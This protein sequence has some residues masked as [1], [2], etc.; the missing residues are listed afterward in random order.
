[1]P[2][3]DSAVAPVEPTPPAC[4]TMSTAEASVA[5]L[6]ANG[7]DTIY[8]LP[9]LHN[10]PF[11]DACFRAEG[12]LRLIHPRH[13]QTC[14]YMGLGA[15]L[16]TGKPQV[17][18]VVPGPGFLNT[19]AAVL[20]AEALCAPLLTIA[21]QIPQGDIDR[22]HGHLHEIRDQ[23]GLA[24]HIS[25]LSTRIRAPY[26]APA[27]IE[28]SL[29]AML[30]DRPGPAFIECAMDVWAQRAPVETARTTGRAAPL[31]APV[32]GEAVEKA[33]RIIAAAVNPMI[34]VGGG[35]LEAGEAVRA[36]AEHLEAPVLSYRRGRGVIP[37]DHRLAVSLPVGYRLWPHVDT[38]IAIGTRLFI[39]DKQWGLDRDIKV[40]RIDADPEA[41]GRGTHP[42]VS[43]IGDAAACTTALL[44]ATRS[45]RGAV[46][47]PVPDLEPHNAWLADRLSRLEPQVSYLAA[48]RRA[49]PRDGIFV[50]EVTQV[51]FASRLAFPV[52]EPR[53]FLSPG[54]QDNLGW[55]YGTA[56]GAQAANPDRAVVAVAGDGGFMYQVGEL[57]TAVLHKLPVVVIVF[58]NGMFGNV[59]RIQQERFGN[60]LIASDLANP[61][62]FKLADAFGVRPFRADTPDELERTLAEAIRLRVP[63]L[64]HVPCGEM[65]SAWDMLLMPRIRG[66][67]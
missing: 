14:G 65:P 7:I 66:W 32:D 57:A 51:G 23:R 52:Y 37:S 41:A 2:E 27:V 8:G 4:S 28:R 15:A 46:R 63:S 5:T 24:A 45:M 49:M 60:R 50:D 58:D 1:M 10:D 20:T 6:Q 29:A 64:V 11:F 9:G 17:S 21:G 67:P 13:E 35:A 25:K 62:F 53:T 12:R 47:R 18:V 16:S 36:L 59:R 39:Q 61:D 44:E 38:V 48:I 33:A 30:S 54:Y 40:I 56:L 31:R 43:M 55:G 19:A 34:V 26:E 22:H 3:A 42:A